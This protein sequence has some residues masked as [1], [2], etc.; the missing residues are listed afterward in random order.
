MLAEVLPVFHPEIQ[1]GAK[2]LVAPA[3]L[4]TRL[5]D[6]GERQGV[7]KMSKRSSRYLRT[8]VMEAAQVAVFR[9]HDP[10]F[11]GVYNRHRERG[12]HHL[13][14]LSHVANKMLHVVFSVL[15]NNRPY[16]PI[17][18]DNNT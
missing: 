14:A 16:A 17:L 7:G 5:C 13:V 6:S 4:D 1:H 12:K 3:G 10:L 9:C 18:A 11:E 8:A 15:K 2:K